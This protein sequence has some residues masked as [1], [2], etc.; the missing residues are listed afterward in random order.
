MSTRWCPPSGGRRERATARVTQGRENAALTY[1]SDNSVRPTIKYFD[2][3]W[4]AITHTSWPSIKGSASKDD[5]PVAATLI[6]RAGDFAP[7]RVTTAETG[8]TRLVTTATAAEERLREYGDTGDRRVRNR[9][10]EDHMWLATSIA[11]HFHRGSEPLADLVQVAALGLVKAADRFDPEHGAAFVSFAAVTIR[12]ELRRHY[13]DH[14]WM[15]R[16]PRSLQERRADVRHANE[17]LTSRLGRSPTVPEVARHLRVRT[18]EVIEA[19]AADENYRP[20]SLDGPLANGREASESASPD[21]GGFEAVDDD[22]AFDALVRRCP[23]GLA[24]VLRM[25]HGEH[26][27]QLE[28]AGRMCIS[29]VHV[30]RLL[31]RAHRILRTQISADTDVD[32]ALQRV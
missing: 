15:L 14:G 5:R 17:I 2:A 20:L 8:H 22:D 29:Q 23:D 7:P 21:D 1:L 27:T 16:V 11:R 26:L 28:I 32:Q 4:A 25:R 3:R 31:A 24:A 30:S 10:V 6:T 12:G 18:D 19:W 13:R 9:V